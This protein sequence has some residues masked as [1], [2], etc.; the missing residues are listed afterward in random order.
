MEGVGNYLRKKYITHNTFLSPIFNPNEI[1]L[2]SSDSGRTI[3]SLKGTIRGLY[4][5]RKPF[6]FFDLFSYFR[7]ENNVQNTKEKGT[8]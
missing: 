5:N 6:S 8:I 3:E 4:P 2:R 7:S 1:Y